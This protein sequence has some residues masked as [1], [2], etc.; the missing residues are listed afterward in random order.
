MGFGVLAPYPMLW[1]RELEV[2]SPAG[3]LAGL[4]LGGGR[5]CQRPPWVWGALCTRRSRVGIA[6]EVGTAPGCPCPVVLT[7]PMPSP[8]A[9]HVSPSLSLEGTEI[10]DTGTPGCS[11]GCLGY[12]VSRLERE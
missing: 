5:G 8:W 9:M 7:V 6:A 11:R 10:R 3:G 4:T 2:A 1:E 12:K